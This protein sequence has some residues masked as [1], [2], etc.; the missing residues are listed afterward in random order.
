MIIKGTVDK[1]KYYD[2]ITLMTAAKKLR[3][4]AG[5]I[6]SAVIMGTKENKA[7]LKASGLYVADFDLSS[8]TDMLIAIKAKNEKIA[9]DAIGNVK[10]IL[11]NLKKGGGDSR[12][13]KPRSI[14]KAVTDFPDAN[15]ALISV[16]GKYAGAEAMKALKLGLHVMLFSD[17][18][19]LETE[20]ELKKYALQK[21]LLLMGPDC[22]TAIINGVPLAFA[23]VVPKGK[24]G[25]VAA[26]GT[27]LQETSCL[28]A[29]AGEGISQA[30]GVGS[31]D[32]G[33]DVG[34]L[35]FIEGIRRLA[36]DPETEVILLVSKPPHESVLKKIGQTVKNIKK[37][38]VA[39]FLG[40][41]L[42]TVEKMKMIPAFSLDDA[43]AVAIRTLRKETGTGFSHTD[44]YWKK[45]FLGI[46]NKER[47]GISSSQKYIRGLFSGGTFC[48]E[49]QVLLKNKLKDIYSNSPILSVGK[50]D[51]PLIS[52]KNSL[53]DLG[54]D[55]FTVGRPHPMID[56]SLRN[57]RIIQEASDRTVAVILLDIVLGYGDNPNPLAEI[58][59]AIQQA[60]ATAKKGRRAISIICS[61]TGT[62]KDPQNRATIVKGLSENGVTVMES[63]AAACRLAGLIVTHE[64]SHDKT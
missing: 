42:K 25:I 22:G 38:V 26:S 48:N 64:V 47:K 33:K 56:Y 11:D 34:G 3:E 40:A 30:I 5:V 37:P 54:A 31:R 17:N 6:D 45:H 12:E 21:G 63:N 32:I 15:L 20:I 60:K 23:N 2:S 46:I 8:D 27:G 41:D 24:I 58:V 16:A 9:D 44:N 43:A 51:N 57:K 61:V 49:A 35:M 13:F 36:K 59:P 28:I 18:V 53:I 19:P 55:E 50:L 4:L 39:V 62:D 52:E 14:Q 7:I 29:N 10:V 1:G